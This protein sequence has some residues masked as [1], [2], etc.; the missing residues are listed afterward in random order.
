MIKLSLY[1]IT[2]NEEHRLGRT[3]KAASP[4]VDEIVVVD[5]GSIDRTREIAE[6]YGARF[7]HNDWVS[8]GVRFA[9]RSNTV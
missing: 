1:V 9:S 5:C 3:L 6:S 7:Y 8:F 4:L 2:Y